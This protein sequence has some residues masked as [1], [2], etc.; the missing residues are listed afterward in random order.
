MLPVKKLSLL[1]LEGYVYAS[2][3]RI[4]DVDKVSYLLL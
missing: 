4:S 1:K 2:S 3:L